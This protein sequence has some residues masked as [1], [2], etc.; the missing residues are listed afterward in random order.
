MNTNKAK[1]RFVVIYPMLVILIAAASIWGLAFSGA[2][3][4]WAG[5]LLTVLPF[6]A[7]YLRATRSGSLARTSHRLPVLSAA[8]V[9][10]GGMA[11][12]GYLQAGPDG[13]N[14]L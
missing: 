2:T 14:V 9:T 12:Y 1:A 6:I 7:L 5:A 3:L 13:S 4:A 10:G 11:I 8:T